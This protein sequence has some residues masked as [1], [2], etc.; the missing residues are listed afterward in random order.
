[1][2]RLLF[3][4]VFA[5]VYKCIFA[6][7]IDSW[8]PGDTIRLNA[9]TVT[10][11]SISSEE[12]MQKFIVPMPTSNIDAINERI[13]QITTISRGP[14]AREPGV[15]GFTSGQINVTIDG[16]KMFGACTDKMDP[17]TSYVEPV[18]LVSINYPF[19]TNGAIYGSTVGGTYNMQLQLPQ[20]NTF[21]TEVGG[22]Y[23]SAAQG[24]VAYAKINYGKEKWAYRVSGVYRDFQTYTNGNGN[25]VPFTQYRKWNMHNSLLYK[26]TKGQTLK[27]D[28]ILDDAY[29]IGYPA[30]PMDVA[31]AQGRIYAVTYSAPSTHTKFRYL[32]AK[33]YANTVYHLMDDSQRDSLYIVE[34]QFDGQSDSVYMRM[35]MPGWSNTYGG[36]AQ[37]NLVLNSNSWFKFKVENYTNWSK[38]EMT[39]YMNNLSN[40]GEP[41]MF[42]ETWPENLRNVAGVFASYTQQFNDL[43][44]EAAA[45]ADVS[46]SQLLTDQGKKQFEILGYDVQ[47]TFVMPVYTLHFSANWEVSNRT[48]LVFG[49]GY[50]Q[51]LPTLSEQ[52]GFYLFNAQDGYDYIGNPD[53]KP[54]KALNF[55]LNY[56]YTHP[57]LKINWHNQIHWLRDYIYGQSKPEYGPLNLYASGLKQY[58]NL[59]GATLFSSTAQLLYKPV[60][61]LELVDMFQ[62]YFGQF[63]SDQPMPLIAPVKNRFSVT[64]RKPLWYLQ[65]ENELSAAQNRIDEDFGEIPTAGFSLI[66]IR[67]GCTFNTRKLLVSLT[68]G[69]EN[70]FDRAYSE[71]LDWGTYL[72]PGRNLQLGATIKF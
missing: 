42:V 67:G 43:I 28:V 41:P 35:D 59:P 46:T 4:G 22:S 14:Y 52:F 11:E 16:M 27:L 33:I 60:K 57:K 62:Y 19:G 1:M 5:L 44:L 61:W 36:F 64:Y 51:R 55:Q 68:A 8:N 29:D 32:K 72:R 20:L 12:A 53:L 7:E 47:K 70:I 66:H 38:A 21:Y 45:R 69:V 71:H 40:P 39:M 56:V 58:V 3:I 54:E 65:A 50:G 18:N 2:K 34:N 13:P 63:D 49:A 10:E 25:K 37:A 23:E 6:E 26:T 15:A 9:V 30:L 17:I 48:D 31:L 24:K